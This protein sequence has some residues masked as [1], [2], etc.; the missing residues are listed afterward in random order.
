MLDSST[1]AV[2]AIRKGTSNE[3]V[4]L[5]T[6]CIQIPRRIFSSQRGIKSCTVLRSKLLCFQARTLVRLVPELAGDFHQRKRP[7]YLLA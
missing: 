6:L 2:K 5:Y 3:F 7:R 1:T 4:L